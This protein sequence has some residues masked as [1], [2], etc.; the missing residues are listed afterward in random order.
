MLALGETAIL[1]GLIVVLALASVAIWVVSSGF[2]GR[3]GPVVVGVSFT[4]ALVGVVGIVA[5]ARDIVRAWPPDRASWY[6]VIF[7]ALPLAV[8]VVSLITARRRKRAGRERR[9]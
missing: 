7:W 1:P 4:L 5:C 2:R 9:I 8:G 6:A 3:S